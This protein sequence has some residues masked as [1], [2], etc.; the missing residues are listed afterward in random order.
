MPLT[1]KL[2]A[3]RSAG[4]ATAG[5]A[6]FCAMA[7]DARAAAIRIPAVPRHARIIIILC[8][9]NVVGRSR[10]AQ[11]LADPGKSCELRVIDNVP[12]RKDRM[13][14]EEV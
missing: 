6:P 13:K 3:G 7:G 12:F 14:L 10:T 4:V 9:C 11:C 8:V 1:V 5:V 2:C